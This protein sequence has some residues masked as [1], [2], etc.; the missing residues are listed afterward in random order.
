MMDRVNRLEEQMLQYQASNA[1]GSGMVKVIESQISLS[2]WDKQVTIDTP[3]QVPG[4]WIYPATLQLDFV[5]TGGIKP[6]YMIM[7]DVEINGKDITNYPW[8]GDVAFDYDKEMAIAGI[9]PPTVAW[10]PELGENH[11]EFF[12]IAASHFIQ[13]PTAKYKLR[14]YSTHECTITIINEKK[15]GLYY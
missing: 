14:L 10:I 11:L 2:E 6:P 15:G 12:T 3:E 7:I 1:F 9:E 8:H 5:G 13:P 4:S